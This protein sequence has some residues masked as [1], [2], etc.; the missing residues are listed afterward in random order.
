MSFNLMDCIEESY[1]TKNGDPCWNITN[2][3]FDQALYDSNVIKFPA[4]I[5]RGQV[6]QQVTLERPGMPERFIDRDTGEIRSVLIEKPRV[7]MISADIPGLNWNG[8][9]GTGAG[10]KKRQSAAKAAA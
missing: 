9:N 7:T 4:T 6:S 3:D 2:P 10:Q 1:P 8:G 5:A